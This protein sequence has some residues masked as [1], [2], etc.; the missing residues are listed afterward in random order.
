[1]P[2]GTDGQTLRYEL[3][4]NT[5]DANSAIV[6]DD[7]SVSTISSLVATTADIEA[8]TVDALIGGTTPAE[9]TFTTVN[10]TTYTG[11]PDTSETVSGIIEL[12]TQAEVD[13]GIDATRAVT[14]ATL[15]AWTGDSGIALTDLSA[16][17]AAV[18]TANLSYNNTNGVFTY[19][20]P[21]L[22]TYVTAASATAFTN[23][24][25]AIS[26]WTNDSGYL[27]TAYVLP[28]ASATVLGGVEIF[29]DVV[30]SVAAN[31][32]T[33]TASKT[34]GVQLDSSGRSVVNVPWSAGGGIA[35]TDLSAVVTAVGTAN[36]SYDNTSGVFTYTPP[37]L[38]S[39]ATATSATAFTN[40][41]GNISQ[42]TNDSGYSTTTGTVTPSSTDTFTNKS[43]DISQWTN[44]S[45]YLTSYTETDTLDSVTTRGNT[46]TNAITVGGFTSTGID[47][48]A[49]SVAVTIDAS[50]N[51]GIG[52]NNP[53]SNLSVY[54]DTQ[55]A[56]GELSQATGKG[57]IQINEA[58]VSNIDLECGLEFKGSAF[59]SGY[60][61]KIVGFDAGDMVFASRANS[62]TFTER[63]RIDS[64]GN[65]GIQTSSPL[66]VL[67]VEGSDYATAPT[68][69]TASSL[70]LITGSGVYSGG[71]LIFG[72]AQSEYGFAGIKGLLTGGGTNT[73]G[74][75]AFYTR[76]A[77]ADAAMTE[78]MK[79]LANGD[80]GIGTTTPTGS[81][82]HVKGAAGNTAG[83][84]TGNVRVQNPTGGSG[85]TGYTFSVDPTYAK[86]GI[87]AT[88]QY[89]NGGGSMIFAVDTATDAADV[90]VTDEK[91][92]ID[93]AGVI[94]GLFTGVGV[95]QPSSKFE[96]VSALPGSP[97]AN[98]IYFVT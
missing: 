25:G 17:V 2:V 10:A 52:T 64:S 95:S 42:W 73:I 47:D 84:I 78:R 24:T 26:Q 8:G 58:G 50:E 12:A 29:S 61:S 63:M 74:H 43:G 97:D 69:G 19:T 31:A 67:Q 76:N 5:W 33:A 9:G 30:Q 44:D 57:V 34:Y 48:N 91:M 83:D 94:T 32:V 80:V 1:M 27:T 90:A 38:S 65:V 35:L 88:R 22:T 53:A 70:A 54:S 56:T 96:V 13:A 72:A 49:T 11:L 41:T 62:S 45:G 75:L 55:G 36:L 86:Q 89:A 81:Q 79:I 39:Y 23:K 21:D 68:V 66:N 28:V 4:T 6:I 51:V 16:S 20:P 15:A 98:T 77:E 3:S 92:R 82:L 18:G 46:T 59:G 85:S 37:D 14:S 40:K 87:F 7:A 71:S 60:G 93:A